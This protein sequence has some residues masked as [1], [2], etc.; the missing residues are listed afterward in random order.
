MCSAVCRFAGGAPVG[1]EESAPM[2]IALAADHAGFGYKDR[3]IELLK[4][5]GHEPHDFGTANDAPV[6]YP[7]Y[8]FVV[9][10]AVASGACDRGI[11]VCGSSIGISIAANKIEG[12]R[13]AAIFEPYSCELSRRHNDANILALSE[14]L[15]GWEMVERLVEVFLT[16][17]FESGGRH[18]HRV[19]K[20]VYG[21]G[22]L[23][24]A[25]ADLAR[26]YVEGAE[27]P[28]PW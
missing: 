2:K 27:T 9:G 3:I 22:E 11:V 13:C 15:T 17:P 20:L 8:G 6:D 24:K 25:Q 1:A 7:D 5:G 19:A 23:A 16:T 12:I 4:T 10:L 14:R 26:G 21:A 18:S 28:K